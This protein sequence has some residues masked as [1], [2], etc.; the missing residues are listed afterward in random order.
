LPS[1]RYNSKRSFGTRFNDIKE[2]FEVV[3]KKT[4][5]DQIINDGVDYAQLEVNSIDTTTINYGGISASNFSEG[6]K[7]ASGESNQRVPSDLT[8]VPYWQEVT[9]GLTELHKQ[10]FHNGEDIQNVEATSEGILFTPTAD[11]ASRIYLTGRIPIPKSRK[12]YAIWEADQA[13]NLRLIWWKNSHPVE[14]THSSTTTGVATITTA[15][16]HGWVVG[17]EIRVT[18][19]DVDYNGYH[20]ITAIGTNSI[21]YTSPT[22]ASTDDLIEEQ[23]ETRGSV[24]LEDYVYEELTNKVIWDANYRS[25]NV[26][27]KVLTNNLATLTTNA[28]HSFVAGDVVKILDPTD[29]TAI[30]STFDGTYVVSSTTSNTISYSKIASNVASTAVSPVVEI[31]TSDST[32]ATEYSIYL[33]VA[34]GASSV[35]LKNAKV[36]EVIGQGAKEPKYANVSATALISN[37]AYIGTST[38]HGFSV[39]STVVL[40]NVGSPYDGT[41]VISSVATNTFTYT[42]VSANVATN[43]SASGKAVAYDGKQHS[44]LAPDGLRLYEADGT[45]AV[46]LTTAGNSVFNVYSNGNVVMSI[47][48]VGNGT[49]ASLDSDQFVLNGIDLV[50]TFANAEFNGY[51]Y[52]KFNTANVANGEI[53]ANNSYLNW[54]AR[55]VIYEGYSI[56]GTNFTLTTANTYYTLASGYFKVEVGRSYS[57]Q[58]DYGSLYVNNASNVAV[59][60]ILKMGTAPLIVGGANTYYL[61]SIVGPGTATTLGTKAAQFDTAIGALGY[62]QVRV[63]GKRIQSNVVTL[64]LEDD[65][66]SGVEGRPNNIIGVT[67]TGYP[68]D[69]YVVSTASD[70]YTPNTVSYSLIGTRRGANSATTSRATTTNLAAGSTTV[71]VSDTTGLYS[72]FPLTKTAG[73]G[74]FGSGAVVNS[75]INSTS[76]TTTTAHLVSGGITFSTIQFVD[77]SSS[78][79]AKVTEELSILAGVLPPDT[80]IYYTIE[81]FCATPNVNVNATY[82]SFPSGES[83]TMFS[84]IDIGQSKGTSWTAM[85]DL[86]RTAVGSTAAE[87]GSGGAGSTITATVTVS[88]DQSA[89]YDNYGRGTG[90]SDPY[91]YRYSLYQGNPGTSSGTKK[92]AIIFPALGLP[93]GAT[94]TKAELYLRNRHSYSAS[95]LTCYIGAHIDTDLEDQTTAPV[96]SGTLGTSVVTTTFARGQ[97]KWVNITS[98]WASYIA[99]GTLKGFLIGL[100]TASNTW[101]SSLANYGYFDGNTMSDEPRLRVTYQYTA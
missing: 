88:A 85:D 15:T 46:D 50:G 67:G 86:G 97:G 6:A 77:T 17:N 82:G 16:A 98:P 27:N 37:V 38:D 21:S 24:N 57:L 29:G 11:E 43:L 45:L 81:L 40:S 63:I 39:D 94:V 72:G 26:S 61:R 68:Y 95:G 60:A 22:I 7:I 87:F 42:L 78:V 58:L 49:F 53:E 90:T 4:P 18:G 47:D 41:Y 10:G 34:A 5:P 44:E 52:N 35:L 54:L 12:V 69:G 28:N 1:K 96:Q 14:V 3:N 91:A 51:A 62:P 33:E 89:Y 36:F 83:T 80:P 23:W 65:T 100:S 9:A 25:A 73:T 70:V 71:F 32:S 13:V 8:D 2:T 76:F 19:L 59:Q 55:G 84:V 79:T 31:K 66:F 56:L 93:A 64:L 75:V 30:D 101:Y 74:T 99:S 92:S 20:T 48:D